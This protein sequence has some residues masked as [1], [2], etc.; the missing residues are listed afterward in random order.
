M[1][2]VQ[3]GITSEKSE[4]SDKIRQKNFETESVSRVLSCTVIYLAFALPQKSL[5]PRKFRRVKR[6]Q[7]RFRGVASDRVYTCDTLL[8][9]R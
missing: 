3:I 8:H 2:T 6:R 4:I 7:S 9:R 5:P 1:R